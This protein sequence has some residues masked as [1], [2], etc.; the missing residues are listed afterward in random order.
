ML[1]IPHRGENPCFLEPGHLIVSDS[2]LAVVTFMVLIAFATSLRFDRSV[3]SSCVLNCPTCAG[4]FR[5]ISL[6]APGQMPNEFDQ[7]TIANR[8]AAIGCIYNHQ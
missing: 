8:T 4:N 6:S 5:K 7:N 2:I 1:T 3:S